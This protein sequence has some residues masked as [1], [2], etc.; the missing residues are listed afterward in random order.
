MQ[1]IHGAGH[2]AFR[3]T[4]RLPAGFRHRLTFRPAS[5]DGTCRLLPKAP[6]GRSC[7][8]PGE[9]RPGRKQNLGLNAGLGSRKEWT[10]RES[11]PRPEQ[12]S[13]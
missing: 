4:F 12:L 13:V 1:H 3:L 11:N 10:R 8:I 6:F 9:F 2:A 5:L 7:D